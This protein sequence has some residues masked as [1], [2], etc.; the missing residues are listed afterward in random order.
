[1]HHRRGRR[2]PKEKIE[3]MKKISVLLSCMVLFFLFSCKPDEPVVPDVPQPTPHDTV[4]TVTIGGM[5]VLNEG[6]FTYAN[7]SLTYYNQEKDSV[8]NYVFLVANG[9]PIGDVGQSLALIEDQLFIVVNNSKYIYKVNG[10]TFQ[11]DLENPYQ[12]TGFISPRYMLPIAS[13]KAYV[14]DLASTDLWIINPQTMTHT[15]TIPMGNSTENMIRVG[16]EVYVTHWSCFYDHVDN[17][18]V[19]VIDVNNDV[20]IADITVGREPNCLVQ[21]KHG[22]I[23]VMCE[24]ES[25]DPSIPSELWKIDPTTKNSTM[26]KSFD[27]KAMNLAIDPTGTYLYYFRGNAVHRASIESPDVEDDFVIPSDGGNFY[28]LAVDPNTGDVYVTDAKNYVVDGTVYRYAS[29]G[30]LITSFE[31]GI[32]PSF[33]LFY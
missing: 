11:C 27:G 12:I 16:D 20:K 2:D 7:S 17:T 5:L 26:V 8:A 15:G 22:Y 1:M 6:T 19:Q 18:N 14:S 31:A 21:D 3:A 28:K 9:A 29:D 24:G 30:T 4:P 10:N 33:M 23:W 13:D 32:C 25:L